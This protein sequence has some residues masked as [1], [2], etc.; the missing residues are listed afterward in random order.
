MPKKQ[1]QIKTGEVT[2]AR[3]KWKDLFVFE[4]YG[5]GI[6]IR[7]NAEFLIDNL[8]AAMNFLF[9]TGW[10]EISCRKVD[11][12]ELE[13]LFSIY[14]NKNGEFKIY[15]NGEYV[16]SLFDAEKLDALESQLRLTVAEFAEDF[17]FLHAGAV[18]YRDKAII[19][20]AK[21]FAGKTTLV[22]EL[23]KRGLEYYSDEYAVIDRQ[24]LLHPFPKKL[25]V[26]GIID[27]Y[28]QIEM[29]VEEW[30]GIKGQ[31]PIDVGLILVTKYKKQAK[32]LPVEVSAG[33]GIIES[34]ANSVSIRQ[35]PQMVLQVLS[36]VANQAKTIKTNRGE[37]AKFADKFL[38]YLEKTGF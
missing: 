38:D 13:H 2:P 18:A 3:V 28:T 35:N 30:G 36:I 8:R 9:P 17:V 20:P 6:G 22:A 5:V 19:I 4:T 16:A 24:G 37:A 26:R 23:T 11:F 7:V 10:R 12:D 14:K 33:E 29:D 25:S 31:K 34:I 15:K 21:S 32:F 27:D 1:P